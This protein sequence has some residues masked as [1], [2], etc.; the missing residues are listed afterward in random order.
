MSGR[1]LLLVIMDDEDE[2][3]ED[4]G[5]REGSENQPNVSTSV[6]IAACEPADAAAVAD[7]IPFHYYFQR[8]R[9]A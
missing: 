7:P 9:F 8:R 5:W 3:G 2:D 6:T 4:D 1:L